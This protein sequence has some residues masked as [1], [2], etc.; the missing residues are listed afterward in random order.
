LRFRFVLTWEDMPFVK[1]AETR[2]LP[3]NSVI[4]VLV[5][6]EPIAI[7]NVAGEIH[8]LSGTC[9]HQGGPLG[10]GAV[11][12]SS[13]TCPWH[14]WDFD[15]RTGENDFDRAKRVDVYRVRVEAG[16]ISIELPD[17]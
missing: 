3:P 4:E 10:Q 2:E 8:A 16:E 7:C 6:S 5:G 11:N 9:P 15:C 17:A 13:V 1:V 14:A 12:G